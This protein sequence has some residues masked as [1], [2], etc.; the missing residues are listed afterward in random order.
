[1]FPLPSSSHGP[2]PST[3]STSSVIVIRHGERADRL[4]THPWNK[5]R[6][7][8]R[9]D[10]PLTTTGLS[11]ALAAA[12]SLSID[13]LFPYPSVVI[14]SS[15][16]TRCLQTSAILSAYLK[17]PVHVVFSL[18]KSCK[19][20]RTCIKMHTVPEVADASEAATIIHSTHPDATFSSYLPDDGLSFKQSLESLVLKNH[21]DYSPTTSIV[22]VVVAH[23]ESQ[24]ELAR[25][26][27][28][29]LLAT[30]PCGRASFQFTC[31]STSSPNGPDTNSN[32]NYIHT[33]NQSNSTTSTKWR[34]TESP[35]EH[36]DRTI[37]RV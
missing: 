30:P 9:Q 27:G 21:S 29:R 32:N 37:V 1:M 4:S 20:L 16:L 35:G 2:L 33:N 34:L 18:S 22:S 7:P 12:T 25:L 24:A 11:Q 15:P 17:I 14:Y 13:N 28:N 8:R 3:V 5:H 6:K 19:Y 26:S 36:M 10:P 31:S 23:K